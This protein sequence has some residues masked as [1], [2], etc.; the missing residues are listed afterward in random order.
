MQRPV[1]LPGGWVRFEQKAISLLNSRTA[2]YTS[3]P[4]GS[5]HSSDGEADS[6]RPNTP[7]KRKAEEGL[8]FFAITTAVLAIGAALSPPEVFGSESINAGFLHAL[9]QQALSIWESSSA[10]KS[11]KDYVLFLVACLAGIGYTLLV[12]QDTGDDLKEYDTRGKAKAIF[13]SV[14]HSDD[15]IFGC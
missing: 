6:G 15:G 11:E 12:T 8:P 7:S 14:S 9:S 1:P 10:K 3:P 5:A 2:S 4:L 13:A